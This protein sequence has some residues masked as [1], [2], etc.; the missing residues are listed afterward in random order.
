MAEEEAEVTEVA[1]AK[2]EVEEEEVT[3]ITNQ[4]GTIQESSNFIPMQ[5]GNN[6]EGSC[7]HAP[8]LTLA[9]QAR[10][11]RFS[12]TCSLSVN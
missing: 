5:Q 2:E 7:I 11:R 12:E 4:I 3:T 9:C 6:S 8:G 10:K 1:E